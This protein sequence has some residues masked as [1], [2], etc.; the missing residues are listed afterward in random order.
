MSLKKFEQRHFLLVLS[1]ANRRWLSVE[2]RLVLQDKSL[3]VRYGYL[4][5]S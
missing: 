5:G 4:S 3:A 1:E 2:S